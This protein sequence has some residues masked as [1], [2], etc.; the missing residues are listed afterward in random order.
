MK[1]ITSGKFYSILLSTFR[2]HPPPN[3]RSISP[4]RGLA[5]TKNSK[6]PT[7]P[8]LWEGQAL[9]DCSEIE[10]TVTPQSE[11]GA[12]PPCSIHRD[13]RDYLLL[14]YRMRSR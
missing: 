6:A 13:C 4:Y 12:I 11:A 2:P 14:E 5:I 9:F 10:P 7:P 1:T 3:H 8:N